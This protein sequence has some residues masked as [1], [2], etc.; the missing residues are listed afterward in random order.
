MASSQSLLGEPRASQEAEYC[1]LP[2][3]SENGIY[4]TALASPWWL[5]TWAAQGL[6]EASPAL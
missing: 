3:A 1:Q 4:E 5:A 2:W 6:K